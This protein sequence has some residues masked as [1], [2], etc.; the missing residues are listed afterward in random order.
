MQTSRLEELSKAWVIPESSS[1]KPG[2]FNIT[3]CFPDEKHAVLAD[4]CGGIFILETGDR[5]MDSAEWKV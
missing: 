5:N 4:G 1:K 2:R 3:L